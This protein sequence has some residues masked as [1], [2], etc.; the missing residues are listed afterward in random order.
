MESFEEKPK[1]V[2]KM[3]DT[4]KLQIQ[5]SISAFETRTN[6]D[7]VKYKKKIDSMYG[8]LVREFLVKLENRVRVAEVT[9]LSL[10]RVYIKKLYELEKKIDPSF[11]L[12]YDEY[13]KKMETSLETEQQIVVEQIERD[14]HESM[15]PT[16]LEEEE[17]NN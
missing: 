11:N 9:S 1:K 5:N 16:K 14:D 7:L 12:S 15:E 3:F 8:V 13:V 4:F 6:D 17:K 2:Q 10:V